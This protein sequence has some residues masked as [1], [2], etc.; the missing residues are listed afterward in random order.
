MRSSQRATTPTEI[1]LGVFSSELHH[2]NY[3]SDEILIVQS[4]LSLSL[5]TTI[6]SNATRVPH[7]LPGVSGAAAQAA[8][9]QAVAAVTTVHVAADAPA[10]ASKQKSYDRND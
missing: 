6:Q 7:I 2:A 10:A 5:P 9:A 1:D 4:S 3:R 8:N